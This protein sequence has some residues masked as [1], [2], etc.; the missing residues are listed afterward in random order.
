[1]DPLSPYLSAVINTDFIVGNKHIIIN[2]SLIILL[3]LLLSASAF[4]S[5]AETAY[6]SI[7]VLRLKS[8]ADENRKGAKK[9]VYI[10]EHFEETLTAILIGNNFVNIAATVVAAY[11]FTGF[12]VNSLLANILNTIIMTLIVIT[13]GEVLPKTKGKECDERVCLK[14]SAT[15][16]ALMKIFHP[17]IK[18]FMGITEISKKRRQKKGTSEKEVT[19]TEDELED[20]IDVMK[21]EGVID[22]QDEELISN[23]VNLSDKT[24]YDIMTPRVDMIALNI[25]APADEVLKIFLE[26][27]YSRLPVY[28][29]DKDNIVGIVNERDFLTAYI[30]KKKTD[31]A[32]LIRKPF[33]VLNSMKVDDL[34]SEMQKLRTHFAV[35]TDEYGGTDGIVTMEDALEELVG[36]I[37][38]EHDDD[39]PVNEFVKINENKY[40]LSPSLELETLF[41][42]LEL[43]PVPDTKYTNIGGYFYEL[44][45]EIP[46]P[47][48]SITIY[49]TFDNHEI[50]HPIVREYQLDFIV[51]KMFKLRIASIEL[52]IT[53]LKESTNKKEQNKELEN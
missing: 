29:G 18:I 32:S 44:S 6:S 28:Q 10:A 31:L 1:M 9:A 27:Q 15:L 41:E 22:Q 25:D 5:S 33:R 24:V 45:D 21:N 49:S 53:V 2:I 4:F 12:F 7:N 34:I 16:F 20:L 50:E 38:D 48:K 43:G 37:Y 26:Y 3:I 46:Y 13:F 40:L 19:V 14:S 35:V 42:N 52:D 47:G 30:T 11:L 23:A 39:V 17:L 36:E 51:K 8:Y